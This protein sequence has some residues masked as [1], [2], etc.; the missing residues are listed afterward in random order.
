MRK[1]YINFKYAV[2]LMLL[3]SFL[4][5]VHAQSRL[6]TGNA[7]T[8]DYEDLNFRTNNQDRM[9]ITSEDT[10]NIP[11]NS[12]GISASGGLDSARGDIGI[13]EARLLID[14]HSYIRFNNP[15]VYSDPMIYMF[16]NGTENLDRMALANSFYH[17]DWGLAR[18]WNGIV[19]LS[20]SPTIK[21]PC[22]THQ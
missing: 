7:G 15:D 1:T 9:T 13:T 22:K 17:P 11:S 8:T 21:V 10:V 14:S 5:L 4:Y 20:T 6:L 18:S 19:S 2:S 3:A 16:Y 12:Y